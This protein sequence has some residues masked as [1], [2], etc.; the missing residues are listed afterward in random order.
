MD[1]GI[2]RAITN[3]ISDANRYPFLFIGS[4]ISRRYTGAPGWEELLECACKNVL[5]EEYAFA[6]YSNEARVAVD[7]GAVESKLPFTATLMEN[8]MNGSLLSD[9]RF[10]CF[11]EKHHDEIVGGVSPLKLYIADAFN[12]FHMS[13]NA[14]VESLRSIGNEKVSGVITTNYD[15]VCEQL[16]PDFKAYIGENDLLFSDPCFTQEI[17]KIHGSASSPDSIV[18]TDADYREFNE[19]RKYLA[20]KLLTIFVEYPVFFLG[21]SLT[22]ENIKGILGEVASCMDSER[23]SR[24]R[25]R[26]LFVRRGND[27]SVDTHTMVFGSS[28]LPMTMITTNDFRDIFE[29]IG[30]SMKLYSPRF[31]R[32]MRGSVYRLAERIDPASDVVVSG[33]DSVLDKIE[34]DKRIVIGISTTNSFGKPITTEDIFEDVVRDNLQCDPRF[35]LDNY[36]NV[37][38]R[39][40]AHAVP[41][42]KYVSKVD[43]NYGKEVT[44]MVDAISSLDYFRSNTIRKARSRTRKRFDASLSISGLIERCGHAGAFKFI[45]I[46]NEDEIDIDDFEQYL[47]Y[48]L[49]HGDEIYDRPGGI[50]KNS[51]F[52]RCVRIFDYLKY[53]NDLQRH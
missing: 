14:E 42:F 43:G 27:A 11:R 31:V 29:A 41:V 40:T 45:H 23:L 18:L 33:L 36:L 6:R 26:L 7:S 32:E 8:D 49:D 47:L 13:D 46:L 24:I 52:R 1:E 3:A 21:Y 25:S 2:R 30:D 48:V 20:A 5:G 35:L 37:F 15:D 53:G 10:R 44:K 38:V 34:P 28:M 12:D 39:R 50:R 9:N 51:D 17:Y 19:R 22:D 16:F 4:G